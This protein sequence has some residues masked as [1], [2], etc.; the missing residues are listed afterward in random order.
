M[1]ST[2][3]G[4]GQVQK[5]EIDF[6]NPNFEYITEQTRVPE[7]AAELSG[8]PLISIDVEATGLDPHTLKLLLL[9]I[10]TE[11][12]AYVFN[13]SLD[14]AQLK[15][16]LEDPKILKILQ[17]GKFDYAA[18]K[19]T[20]KIELNNIY[21][22]MIAER[23]ITTGIRRENSLGAIAK[24]Y[25]DIS[26][27]K[28]YESYNWEE[29]GRT[30]R[31]TQRHLKYAALDVLTLFPI[32][33]KQFEILKKE[34]LLKVSK[35]EFQLISVVAEMELRGSKIDIKKWHENTEE[36]KRKRDE[37]AAQIQVEL[38]PYYKIQQA[39][40][41]GTGSDV[42]NLNSPVQIMEA[43]RKLNIDIASTGEAVLKTVDHPVA[44]LMLQYREAEKLISAFG[45]NFL[46]KVHPKTGRI[47]PD[48][49]QIGADTGRFACS[50]PNLQQIPQDSTFRSCFIPGDGY[51]YVV[52]DY[53][54]IELRI[55]AELSKDPVFLGAFE[56]NEDLHMKTAVNMYNVREEQVDKKMRTAAKTI[57]FG[58]MYGRGP[59]SIGIQIGVGVD[60]ARSLL[61]KYFKAY[62]GVKKWL[63]RAGKEAVHRGFS[64]T[65]LGRKRWYLMPDKADPNYERLLANIERQGK[66]TPIQGTSADITKFALIYINDRI[67]RE[68]L[69]AFLIHTV[70][71]EIV[72]EA[73]AE[74]AQYVRDLVEEEMVRAAK[75]LLKSVK[76]LS[77]VKVAD[78][79]SH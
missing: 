24:K 34:D 45:E 29:V 61:D 52:G 26:L 3:A 2:T 51:K 63:D 73:R 54:Q 40:L 6:K 21:D 55:M 59:A 77:D 60:E 13:A 20:K 32:F 53:S 4:T 16:L 41:F 11:K 58:L 17:N 62:Q 78:Y 12:K 74:V 48:F 5:V 28:D 15:L 71:D 14:L 18:L 7:V 22:T 50:N 47:H 49:M 67:K 79:W 35:L 37:I 9:Q 66:N 42:L 33:K 57:N 30:G 23:I 44:K 31:V 72:T 64:T 75:Q 36:L 65:L 56:K 19:A 70:H 10:G 76:V 38:K 1:E 39:S 43:F 69:D 25:L 8:S 46:E 27:D 68:K